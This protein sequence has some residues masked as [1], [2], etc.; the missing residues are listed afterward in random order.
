[1]N[2]E[3]IISANDSGVRVALTED[4]QLVELH[5]EKFGNKFSVGDI[6][7]G[8]VKKIMQ[9]LNAAFVDLGDSEQDGFMHYLDLGPSYQSCSKYMRQSMNGNASMRTLSPFKIEPT[10]AKD[11]NVGSVLSV[12]QF[13]LVQVSKEPISTKGPKLTGNLSLAGHFVVLTP[14][15]NGVS[16]SQKIKSKEERARLRRLVQSIKPENFGVIVRTNAE[17]KTV[18]EL[19]ADIRNLMAKW[20]RMTDKLKRANAPQKLVSELSAA[21]AALREVL[22]DDFN[23]VYVDDEDVYNEVR[24]YVR[25][26]AP[27][28]E[29]IVRFYKLQTPIFDQFG[30][31]RDIRRAFGKIVTIRSGVYLYVEH[32]EAMHVIDVNSGNHVKSGNGQE[33]TA[34][35]VNIE[36]AIEIARQ[37]RLRDIGG[38]I[39]VDFVDMQRAENRK[40][41]YE[42]MCEEMKK[43]KTRHTILP[44]SKFG[45]MQITRQRLRPAVEMDVQEKCPL[46]DG[47]GKIKSSLV[48]VDEIEADIKYHVGRNLSKRIV[49]YAHPFVQAFLT[50]GL[51]SERMRW[52]RRYKRWIVVKADSHLSLLD[53]RF[54]EKNEEPL[55]K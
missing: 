19:D 18:A 42:V 30:I 26:I 17:G 36:S 14:F 37:L 52:M 10:L 28:K 41:L 6:F 1:M 12:G 16:I 47:T 33:D 11:G 31:T 29:S 35:Q 9:G 49:I 54:E 25:S 15:E 51:P 22:S 39:I 55:S 38:I 8:R 44:L 4:K 23:T 53:Y 21:S 45:L 7:L 40:K 5:T 27:D 43:D 24:S 34:L 3:L 50:K 2:K 13:L 48:V 32:T 20:T 46:C